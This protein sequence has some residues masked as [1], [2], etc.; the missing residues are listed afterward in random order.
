MSEQQAR[1][2]RRPRAVARQDNNGDDDGLAEV[3]PIE[4]SRVDGVEND[5][6]VAPRGPRKTDTEA[7]QQK[8][9]QPAP[10]KPR[11]TRTHPVQQEPKTV[12][13]RSH[14]DTFNPL[15][16]EDDEVVSPTADTFNPLLDEDDDYVD[17]LVESSPVDDGLVESSPDDVD[18]F[19]PLLD[20]DDDDLVESSRDNDYEVVS[21]VEA[22]RQQS[23]EEL[24]AAIREQGL[25]PY[26]HNRRKRPG[27]NKPGPKPNPHS[28]RQQRKRLTDENRALIRASDE[29]KK[30]AKKAAKTPEQKQEAWDNLHPAV[31]KRASEV[32][33]QTSDGSQAESF[34][35]AGPPASRKK[36]T[37]KKYRRRDLTD[38][39]YRILTS[40]AL[41]GLLTANSAFNGLFPAGK[42][43]GNAVVTVRKRLLGL[44]EMGVIS[45]SQFP[46]SNFYVLT[47][48]GAAALES[49]VDFPAEQALVLSP[50]KVMGTKAKHWIAYSSYVS[51]LVRQHGVGVAERGSGSFF[52]SEYS[53]LRDMN[54]E[55]SE[56]SASG[57]LS[58]KVMAGGLN[59]DF[60]ELVSI[61]KGDG[62]QAARE[63]LLANPRLFVMFHFDPLNPEQSKTKLPD[64]V[65]Y[66][67]D[68]D[69]FVAI[70]I[71]T[72]AKTRKEYEDIFA[73]YNKTIG[74]VF[75]RVHYICSE[76][77]IVNTIQRSKAA[78]Q[79]R[80]RGETKR[81]TIEKLHSWKK[82]ETNNLMDIW[83]L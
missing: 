9:S 76:N 46:G 37:D 40:I 52:I 33:E 15:L 78:Q 67:A 3:S 6:G 32:I 19:N 50:E 41:G 8:R 10:R 31:Q 58:R 65:Y 73:M 39:D 57:T 83:A 82:G 61:E 53:L 29:A 63:Y 55:Y 5:N 48:K 17:G 51:R 21:P 35:K 18:D 66:D 1:T 59:K 27:R 42:E 23:D 45:N 30:A 26:A 79:L 4:S 68:K 14:V 75:D 13:E 2:P 56:P 81:L 72:T 74:K 80:G 24:K 7:N 62:K 20:E 70:E 11:A 49:G 54:R 28:K 43:G 22:V 25:D 77:H 44:V 36:K 12:S 16:D 64:G 47:N 71:E 38:K 69:E 60:N 34:K